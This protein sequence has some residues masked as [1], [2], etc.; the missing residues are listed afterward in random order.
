MCLTGEGFLP[1]TVCMDFTC[2]YNLWV[3]CLVDSN[4][5]TA[6]PSNHPIHQPNLSHP[7]WRLRPAVCFVGGWQAFQVSLR[8]GR[9]LHGGHQHL[10]RSQ[11]VKAVFFGT[12]ENG[13]VAKT[14]ATVLNSLIYC[15]HT[16]KGWQFSE[17]CGRVCLHFGHLPHE[18]N[19]I[20]SLLFESDLV[21]PTWWMKSISTV[22]Y[23][24][25]YCAVEDVFRVQSSNLGSERISEAPPMFGW[26]WTW[27]CPKI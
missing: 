17:E 16:T 18:L 27:K 5:P 22:L 2:N 9:L 13:D 3:E 15:T 10:G 19:W 1:S 20:S 12:Q 26:P 24:W 14:V 8:S 23:K 6:Q 4:T 7:F 25:K 21:S 11:L